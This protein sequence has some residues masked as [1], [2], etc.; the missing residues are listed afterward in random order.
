MSHLL[1]ANSG[2]VP[3]WR[4]ILPWGSMVSG[5]RSEQQN[6]PSD[7]A[8]E[9]RDVPAANPPALSESQLDWLENAQRPASESR[10]IDRKLLM[11]FLL[12]TLA[13]AGIL[14][15]LGSTFGF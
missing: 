12:G 3:S 11:V 10:R 14:Y 13:L 5:E 15:L 6:P 4:N 8:S 1:R 7:P 9:T 2:A